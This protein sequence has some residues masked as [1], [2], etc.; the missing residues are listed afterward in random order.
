M[1]H[2][3]LL[4]M[5]CFTLSQVKIWTRINAPCEMLISGKPEA[6]YVCVC[7]VHFSATSLW[8]GKLW[9]FKPAVL[10]FSDLVSHPQ[11]NWGNT[12]TSSNITCIINSFLQVFILCR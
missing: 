5:N 11:R 9:K 4:K 7:C 10:Y 8:E 6:V 2:I 3:S 1:Y 12:Y